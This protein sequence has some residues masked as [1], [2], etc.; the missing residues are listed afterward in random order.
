MAKL[1]KLNLLYI[2]GSI[3]YGPFCVL[4][5][6]SQTIGVGDD[7]DVNYILPDGSIDIIQRN[8]EYNRAR[9]VMTA[10]AGLGLL[11]GVA[12]FVSLI[13]T[14]RSSKIKMPELLVRS[15]L[16]ILMTSGYV[17]V[18]VLATSWYKIS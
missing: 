5:G 10:L 2:I 15:I 6:L 3:F 16:T 4:M 12:S 14:Y 1:L 17:L 18:V 11:L 9:S 13:Y 7:Q 8:S